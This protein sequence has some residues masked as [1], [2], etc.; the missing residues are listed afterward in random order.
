MSA[1][2]A[3]A[4]GG[5]VSSFDAANVATN[6]SRASSSSKKA[7]S[8]AP[9]A[10]TAS[11]L[12]PAASSQLNPAASSQLNPAASSQPDPASS[13]SIYS[14]DTDD[15]NSPRSVGS[16]SGNPTGKYE[17]RPISL[18]GNNVAA[19][20]ATPRPSTN[21]SISNPFKRAIRLQALSSLAPSQGR[22]TDARNALISATGREFGPDIALKVGP[23][24]DSVNDTDISK[25]I[26]E[27]SSIITEKSS[28]TEVLNILAFLLNNDKQRNGSVIQKFSYENNGSFGN[29]YNSLNGNPDAP[30]NITTLITAPS[31]PGVKITIPRTI[32][33]RDDIYDLKNDIIIE[34][35]KI[36]P[37]IS[38][39]ILQMINILENTREVFGGWAKLFK[40]MQ[41]GSSKSKTKKTRRRY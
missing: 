32:L 17:A 26:T 4:G 23:N 25:I 18:S 35:N 3:R 7:V 5:G 31:A 13:I 27:S 40:G 1:A 20:L 36:Q 10:T 38:A 11:Q 30:F 41:G 14:D 9:T 8:I 15:S 34:S 39:C 21:Q 6:A 2:V 24:I 12:N 16:Q 22:N 33:R 28:I 29:V 37:L 19:A